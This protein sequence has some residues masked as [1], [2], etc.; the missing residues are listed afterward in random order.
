[1]TEKARAENMRSG[2]TYKPYSRSP[3]RICWIIEW[4]VTRLMESEP[5]CMLACIKT[6]IKAVKKTKIKDAI[7]S[8]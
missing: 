2:D 3:Q 7:K 1:M 6:K 8:I 4:T 5:H